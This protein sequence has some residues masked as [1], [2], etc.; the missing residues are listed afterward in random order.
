M[1]PPTE[2]LYY[3]QLDTDSPVGE[4]W[5]AVSG[6]GLALLSFDRDQ[7]AFPPRGPRFKNC[8]WVQSEEHTRPYAMQLAEYF[9]GRRRHFDLPLDLR[10]TP[11]QKRCWEALLQIPYGK[12]TSYA[13]IARAVGAPQGFRAVG[14]ANNRNPVAIIVPCH[15]VIASGGTLCGYGGG[16]PSKEWLLQLEGASWKAQAKTAGGS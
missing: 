4:I 5:L 2:T 16:L 15:R 9:A 13:E 12:T 1:A 8:Q 7:K 11:F 14:M 6:R 3:S 10:G